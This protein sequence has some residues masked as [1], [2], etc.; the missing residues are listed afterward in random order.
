MLG[1]GW[2]ELIAIPIV[3]VVAAAVGVVLNALL[4]RIAGPRPLPTT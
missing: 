3:L 4:T 2:W 1:L